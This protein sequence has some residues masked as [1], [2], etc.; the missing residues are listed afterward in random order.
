MLKDGRFRSLKT[1]KMY[2]VWR[3][4]RYLQSSLVPPMS[5]LDKNLKPHINGNNHTNIHAKPVYF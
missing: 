3:K 1:D 2:H 4:H 5:H